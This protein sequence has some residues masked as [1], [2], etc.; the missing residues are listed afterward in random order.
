MRSRCMG[1]RLTLG[2]S[3]RVLSV[4]FEVIATHRLAGEIDC[5]LKVQVANPLAY[6]RHYQ[7]LISEVKVFN[8]T[9]LLSTEELKCTTALPL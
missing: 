7:S 4:N 1:N 8:V 2:T 6:D 5:L 9:A 3:Y